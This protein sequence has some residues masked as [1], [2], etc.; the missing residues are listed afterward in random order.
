VNLLLH[1]APTA[2]RT[3][4]PAFGAVPYTEIVPNPAT[5]PPRFFHAFASGGGLIRLGDV[6][7]SM[8]RRGFQ[9]EPIRLT[10][11]ELAWA[12][13]IYGEKEWG[14]QRQAWLVTCSG[15]VTK[16]ADGQ[17]VCGAPKGLEK[18]PEGEAIATGAITT[19]DMKAA[20]EWIDPRLVKFTYYLPT[21]GLTFTSEQFGRA[22][23]GVRAWDSTAA[24]VRA[25]R[26]FMDRVGEKVPASIR[27][28][29]ERAVRLLAE[30]A[31]PAAEFKRGFPRYFTS[32]SGSAN[33]NRFGFVWTAE[34]I[35]LAV[36]LVGGL[37]AVIW[38]N[39]RGTVMALADAQVQLAYDEQAEFARKILSDPKSSPEDR[40][41][42]KE[43]LDNHEKN[44]PKPKADPM[45]MFTDMLKVATPILGIGLLAYVAGPAIKEAG[46][47]AAEQLRYR[48]HQRG[49]SRAT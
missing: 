17:R 48:R 2:R 28:R 11:A 23:A 8:A 38:W 45:E 34:A 5:Q 42:A 12:T 9:V 20:Y 13:R 29:Y 19:A 46:T 39:A 26:P 49:L 32:P 25:M 3:L 40:A 36:I 14:A 30:N 1:L 21:K 31:Q 33:R 27:V 44:R 6:A 4:S 43:F 47:S 35:V 24:T 7:S 16:D 22:L 18:V 37:A 10:D 41:W 15:E